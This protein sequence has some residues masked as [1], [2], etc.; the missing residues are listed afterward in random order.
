MRI[1]VTN[2]SNETIYENIE[3]E[4]F[5][6]EKDNN[7]DL[8]ETLTLLEYSKTGTEV[9]FFDEDETYCITKLKDDGLYD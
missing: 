1:M 6:F 4:D 5:L 2:D 9:M 3:A 7:E 8:E